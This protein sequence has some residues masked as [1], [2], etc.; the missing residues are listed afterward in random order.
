MKTKL[1]F[2]SLFLYSFFGY[3]Q[4]L[5]I[6]IKEKA[7][8]K[9]FQD[10]LVE[11]NLKNTSSKPIT[12]FNSL[13]TSWSSFNESWSIQYNGKPLELNTF[14][15]AHEGRFTENTIITLKPGEK[16]QIRVSLFKL[17]SP[18]HCVL[19]YTQE[20]SPLLVKKGY[21]ASA[22]A[23]AASQKITSFK[24]TG[25]IEFDVQDSE[26]NVAMD[27]VQMS[28]E[29]WKQYKQKA[30]YDNNNHFFAFD[31]ALKNPEKVYSLSLRCDGLSEEMIKRIGN[32]KNLRSL[33]IS[34]LNIKEFP[35]EI[36][37]LD[38]YEIVI[39]TKEGTDITFPYGISEN[40]TIRIFSGKFSNGFPSAILNL[41]N[42][43]VLS[44]TYSKLVELPNLGTLQNLESIYLGDTKLKTIQNA[45]FDNLPKLKKIA[46]DSNPSLAD[47]TPLTLCSSL[48]EISFSNCN[49]ISLPDQIENLENLKNLA[50][51][52]NKELTMLPATLVNLKNLKVLSLHHTGL[53]SLPTGLSQLPIENLTIYGT[54]CK[55]TDDYKILKKRLKDN[56]RD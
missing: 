40:S 13:Y 15:D 12:Y 31:K 22:S 33:D 3:S 32:F 11:I 28:W 50:L 47:I 24:V 49:L 52:Y 18:G 9:L 34:N 27:K 21:A 17:S 6:T 42:L 14:R 54:N 45:G 26:Q 44:L 41:K 8:Y 7:P 56:F 19:T 39:K 48:E 10:I 51:S 20:Q 2:L 4:E 25:S 30:L 1:F 43:E 29:E 53:Q 23:Y 16:K 46:I 55:K 5:E 36:A 35:K 38:L 37:A